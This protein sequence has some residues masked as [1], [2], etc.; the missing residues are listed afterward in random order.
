MQPSARRCLKGWA[1]LSRK[2]KTVEF[3]ALKHFTNF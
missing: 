3:D 1:A 2:T